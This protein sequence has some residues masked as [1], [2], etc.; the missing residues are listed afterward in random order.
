MFLYF[1]INISLFFLLFPPKQWDESNI[2][3]FLPTRFHMK[4]VG[5][6]EHIDFEITNEVLSYG[7]VRQMENDP[8]LLE[9]VL[10][11]SQ[12]LA[13]AQ[14]YTSPAAG[15]RTHILV[16]VTDA[17]GALIAN[18]SGYEPYSL[19][20]NYQRDFVVADAG[21]KPLMT[22][23]KTSWLF[24]KFK[25]RDV[26][27]GATLASAGRSIASAGAPFHVTFSRIA[28]GI[29]PSLFVLP[30]AFFNTEKKWSIIDAVKKFFRLFS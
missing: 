17:N 19:M 26:D 3:D 29:H 18:I 15:G 27:G 4:N 20:T 12:L 23:T 13:R 16:S 7:N 22:V 8:T 1:Y 6:R 10:D 9:H 5:T 24:T 28:E 25:F 11:D 30:L 21:G 2:S 14:L